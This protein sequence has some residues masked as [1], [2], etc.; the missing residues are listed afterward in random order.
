MNSYLTSMLRTYVPL[1]WGAAL[2]WLVTVGVLDP[3]GALDAAPFGP[4]VLVPITTGAY[5][6]LVRLLESAPWWPRWLSALLLGAPAAPNY[7]P[8]S[9]EDAETVVR[10]HEDDVR[11]IDAVA[12]AIAGARDDLVAAARTTSSVDSATTTFPPYTGGAR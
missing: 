2:A 8:A 5:Y 4:A 1:A 11:T 3:G 7:P 6:A 10:L 9:A 12:A